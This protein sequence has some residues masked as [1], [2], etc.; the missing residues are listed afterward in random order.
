MTTIWSDRTRE[1]MIGPLAVSC[2]ILLA[3]CQTNARA[4]PA[5]TS[6]ATSQAVPYSID[7]ESMQVPNAAKGDG[8]TDDTAALQAWLDAGGVR[9]ADGTY[10][11]TK[12]LILTGNNRS[13]QSLNA[14]IMADGIDITALTITG[15]DAK[16]SLHIDGLNR[17]AYGLKITGSGALIENG[18]Y[19][20]FRSETQSARGIDASTS[21]GIVVRNNWVR[22]VVSVGDNI[23]GNGS[24]AARGIGLNSKE[25]ARTTSF[26]VGNRV[27]NVTG[28]EGDAIHILFFDGA[29]RP[30]A[31]GQVTISDNDVRNVSRRFIKVQA[32]YVDVQRNKLHAD[33]GR[34]PTN[35]SAAIDVIQSEHVKVLDNSIN[36][37]VIGNGIAVNGSAMAPLRGIE[38]RGNVLQESVTL[39]GVGIYLKWTVAPVVRDN[40]VTGASAA[41]QLRSSPNAD[42]EG[43]E[44][45]QNTESAPESK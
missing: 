28:E 15:D 19:E 44:H 37:R 11:I 6:S 32:S 25:A 29:S 40:T 8:I 33:L 38:V 34:D 45:K 30:F 17:A 23:G 3:A 5:T 2:C 24:G 22:N 41:V 39:A 1:W 42:V 36:P 13:L 26:I 9:L 20:N 10:R 7:N 35:P 31:G 12:G 4:V 43:N 16:I 14:T 18:R 27:E 21:G